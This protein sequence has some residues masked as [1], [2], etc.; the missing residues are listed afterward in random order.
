LGEFDGLGGH[1]FSAR[2]LNKPDKVDD[3]T[4]PKPAHVTNRWRQSGGIK[5]RCHAGFVPL[6]TPNHNEWEPTPI[7]LGNHSRERL[8]RA[9]RHIVDAE[10]D[11]WE[12]AL[13]VSNG[14]SGH[15]G[16]SQA[17]F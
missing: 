17:A 7:E 16:S 2:W 9:R 12:F 10:G 8:R 15:Q 11:A 4:F 13:W 14:A 6:S 1:K 5:R 3:V